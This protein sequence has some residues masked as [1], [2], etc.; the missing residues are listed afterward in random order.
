MQGLTAD[1]TQCIERQAG[2]LIHILAVYGL[3]RPRVLRNLKS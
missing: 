1:Q 2:M 3:P